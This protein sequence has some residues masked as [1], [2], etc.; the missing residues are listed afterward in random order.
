MINL[1]LKIIADENIPYVNELFSPF[2]Q[3]VLRKGREICAKNVCDADILLVRSVT[4]VNKALL[5]NSKVK[6][7]GTCTIGIDHLDCNCLDQ[8]HIAWSSA[9]GCNALGVVQYV[10]SCLAVQRLLNEK[11]NIAIVG[12]GNVGGTLYRYLNALG[13]HCIGIDP[14]KTTAEI[15]TLKQFDALYDCDVLCLH[16]P[17][18]TS[19]PHPTLHLFNKSVLQK[20]KPGA[21]LINAGRGG[22]I[23]NQALHDVMQAGQDLTV[24]LDVW[25]QEPD[26]NTA[27]LPFVEIATPHIAGY[28]YEGK[29]NG[30]TMIFDALLKFLKQSKQVSDELSRD[31]E[32][33][34]RRVY[35]SAMGKPQQL[36]A[37]NLE[38]LIVQAY[39]VR[40]DD[41]DLR[42]AVAGLPESFD[43]LRK[44]YPI[45]REPS[46]FVVNGLREG[47]RVRAQKLGFKFAADSS[48]ACT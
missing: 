6:F 11:L 21:L 2:G 24:M 42:A 40:K 1:E 28:S 26:F 38:D 17:L 19:G 20:L 13:Y 36:N 5:E 29:I 3:V 12:C 10:T 27:L 4:K 34:K 37:G 22:V 39:D 44:H 9:P 7:V 46:H 41:Q 31:L 8:Q 45:R 15:P 30:S 23:D 33:R 48:L 25:E 47:D 14:F 35:Q 18:T 32:E 16:T 43:A